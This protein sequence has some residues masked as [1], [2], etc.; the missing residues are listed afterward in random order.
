[1]LLKEVSFA[2]PA[3]DEF[4]INLW[5]RLHGSRASPHPSCSAEM[6]SSLRVRYHDSESF[7]VVFFDSDRNG[8]KRR[9]DFLQVSS[10]RYLYAFEIWLWSLDLALIPHTKVEHS[11]RVRRR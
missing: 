4:F 2:V 8:L 11:G 9:I 5:H 7:T 1:M 10:I 3:M 6:R